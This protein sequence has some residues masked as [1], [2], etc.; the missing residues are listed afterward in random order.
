MDML[1]A[2]T[3]YQEATRG[4][5]EVIPLIATLFC[6]PGPRKLPKQPLQAG[7]SIAGMNEL[8]SVLWLLQPDWRWRLF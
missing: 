5:G 8:V 6:L 2:L 7:A 3:Q 4:S 1:K